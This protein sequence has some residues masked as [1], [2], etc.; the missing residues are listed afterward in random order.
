MTI[1][2]NFRLIN[3]ICGKNQNGNITPDNFNILVKECNFE[4]LSFLIGEAEQYQYN[5]PKARV[6]LGNN[7]LTISKLSPFI[8]A[9]VT[10]TVDN[11]GKASY[12]NDYVE[13]I[14]LYDSNMNK[15]RWAEQDKLPAYL[16]DPI[17]PI[18]TNPIYL[19]ENTNFQFYPI[20]LTSPKLSYIQTGVTPV[21]GYNQAGS[22]L[23]FNNLVNG[24]LYTDGVYLN[25]L[26]RGSY[27]INA[28]ANITVSGNEVTSV[29]LS[30]S[31]A[32]F[33]VGDTLSV[34]NTSIGN[35][36][37]GF[38]IQV[39]SI[40]NETRAVYNPATS[41]DL[42]WGD[43]DQIEVMSRILKKVGINLLSQAVSQYATDLKTTGA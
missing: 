5:S 18:A 24:T 1:D 20:T 41:Q 28:Y 8:P 29:V 3:F 32:N 43:I 21:W 27:G 2:E 40:S 23:T 7:A 33:I 16:T 9:P 25:V 6:E 38:S 10:L 13:R 26:L 22:I 39:A 34:P 37:S 35:T 42:L 14:A 36:G 12:P 11:T 30:N 4:Y 31:G 17:D 19:L 15:I